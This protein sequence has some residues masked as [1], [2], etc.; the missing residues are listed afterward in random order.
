MNEKS[1]N[2]KQLISYIARLITAIAGQE[3]EEKKGP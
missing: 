3:T 2:W 1:N